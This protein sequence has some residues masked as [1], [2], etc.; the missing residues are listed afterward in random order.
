MKKEKILAS[1]E[2]KRKMKILGLNGLEKDTVM[3]PVDSIKHYKHFLHT[4]LL[5]MEPTTG[6]IKAWVGGIN[7]KYFKYDHVMQ[8]KRQLGST[9]K[10]FVYASAIDQLRLSPCEKYPNTPYTIAKE[11]YGMDEDWT[12]KNAGEKY[13][14]E[15]SLSKALAKSVNVITARLIHLVGPAT[16][17]RL[18]KKAG[19][20]SYIP[21]YPS[22]ALGTV[23]AN[24]YELVAA[25]S[26]FANKGI[27]IQPMVIEKITDKYGSVLEQ[28]LPTRKQVLSETSAYLIISLLKGVTEFGSGVRLRSNTGKYPDDIVTGYPYEFKNPIAG[29]TGTT[30]NHSDGWFI[31]IVPNLIT[32]VWTGASNRAIHFKDIARGQGAS[33]SLPIWAIY[34]KKC[35]E[36]ETLNVSVEDFEKPENI[37]V[38]IDCPNDEN[39][40]PFKLKKEN[41]E[42]TDF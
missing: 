24:I 21:P 36:D 18:A 19:F 29:K 4:G 38:Q 25:Y 1:F 42:S 16:V 6:K 33:M 39:D 37:N 13:G 34:M 14:G 2:K 26:I 31:G 5:S 28:F 17:A 22:I 9:F 40:T 27:R 10:P 8:G 30:Q 32:G 20:S 15:L 12:P 35:Y 7:Y 41:E 23:D 3:S 11:S